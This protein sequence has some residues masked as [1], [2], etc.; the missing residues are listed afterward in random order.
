[1]K[2]KKKKQFFKYY[3]DEKLTQILAECIFCSEK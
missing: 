3:Q 1:M 2:D